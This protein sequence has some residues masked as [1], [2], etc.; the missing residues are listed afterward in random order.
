MITVDWDHGNNSKCEKHGLTPEG[1][2]DVDA[3]CWQDD[4]TFPISARYMHTRNVTRH[5]QAFPEN[6][7]RPDH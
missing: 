2:A 3:F 7:P 6:R 5:A 1:R 4:K